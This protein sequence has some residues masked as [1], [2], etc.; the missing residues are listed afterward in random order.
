MN[1]AIAITSTGTTEPTTLPVGVSPI[2]RATSPPTAAA[3][4]PA[5]TKI[6]NAGPTFRRYAGADGGGDR[7]GDH[8]DQ[9]RG[10]DVRQIRGDRR[11]EVR[12]R[13][14]AELR[15]RDRDRAQEDEPE[16]D[17]A[18]RPARFH[19]GRDLVDVLAGRTGVQRA[20]EADE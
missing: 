15:D 14:D 2:V 5:I 20:I 4:A 7:A 19:V 8:E 12:Q 6:R 11:D 10:D 13:G 17:R 18:D 16:R 1:V 3:I 9:D